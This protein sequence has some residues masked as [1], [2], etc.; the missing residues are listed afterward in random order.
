MHV[1]LGVYRKSCTYPSTIICNLWPHWIFYRINNKQPLAKLNVLKNFDFDCPCNLNL[2][3]NCCTFF[4]T[5]MPQ[6]KQKNMFKLKIHHNLLYVLHIWYFFEKA[7]AYCPY[8]N[9]LK[10][11]LFHMIGHAIKLICNLWHHWILYRIRSNV[12]HICIFYRIMNLIDQVK[13]RSGTIKLAF[14][15]EHIWK[16]TKHKVNIRQQCANK[17]LS[18]IT[19]AFKY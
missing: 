2:N 1:E 8:V 4:L 16:I 12:L 17:K 5:L 7:P 18:K 11:L 9:M 19:Q 6:V 14:P 13:L 3:L 15:S 10:G